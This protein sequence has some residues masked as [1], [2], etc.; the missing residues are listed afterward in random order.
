MR[1]VVPVCALLLAR[2]AAAD[3]AG[4]LPFRSFGSEQG[5]DNLS[6]IQITQTADGLMWFATEDGLY[7]YDG[8]R[9]HRFDSRDGLPSNGIYTLLP[10]PEGLWVGT[11]KGLVRL[12]RDGEL[13]ASRLR[14]AGQHH[15][16]QQASGR[17]GE[18][19]RDV[20][21]HV[22]QGRPPDKSAQ[23]GKDGSVTSFTWNASGDVATVTLRFG[24]SPT[25]TVTTY[26]Y[27]PK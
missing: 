12:D 6:I 18:P 26:S 9:F 19:T 4:R 17:Q 14:Q 15:T 16:N 21:Q 10:T 22:R 1:S 5:L 20:H 2:A 7:S 27:E 8:A 13:R 11:A 23:S 3:P 24:G 25:V